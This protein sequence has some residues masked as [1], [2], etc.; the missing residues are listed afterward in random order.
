[1]LFVLYSSIIAS[2]AG[3]RISGSVSTVVSQRGAKKW[4]KGVLHPRNLQGSESTVLPTASEVVVGNLAHRPPT[5]YLNIGSED[6]GETDEV[7]RV[8]ILE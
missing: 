5:P 4:H 1:M 3:R 7:V 6:S 8:C 2:H